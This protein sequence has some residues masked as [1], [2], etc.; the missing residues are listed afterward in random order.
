MR[1]DRDC[2]V[3]IGQRGGLPGQSPTHRL[4][5]RR[6]VTGLAD[7][8]D[9]DRWV[10]KDPRRLEVRRIPVDFRRRPELGHHAVVHQRRGAAQHESLFRLGGGIDHHRPAAREKFGQLFAEFLAKLVVE[11]GERLIEEHRAAVFG[12]R[13]GQCRPLLLTAGQFLRPAVQHG[14]ELQQLRRLFDAAGDF[15]LGHARDPER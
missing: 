1:P 14:L 5:Q 6:R 12:N 4:V 15:A 11:V 8:R 2:V 3:A 10:G 13:T 7:F 9:I